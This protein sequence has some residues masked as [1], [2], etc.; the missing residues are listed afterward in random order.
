ME[1][2]KKK[3]NSKNGEAYF[4]LCVIVVFICMLISVVIL[5]MGLMAQ[6]RVQKK[7]VQAKLDSLLASYATE[8]YDSLKQGSEKEEYLAWS[9]LESKAYEI[10]GFPNESDTVYLYENG[11][12]KM[13]RPTVTILKGNGFGVTVE[14]LAIFPVQWNG[15]VYSELEIPVTVT[16]YYKMK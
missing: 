1:Q 10:L 4:Y 16:S 6:V 12:C 13:F 3:L 14:Y 8:E 2:I 7:D 5:Y 9:I 11:N 15:V